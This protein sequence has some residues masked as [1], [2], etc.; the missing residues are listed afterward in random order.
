MLP[1]HLVAQDERAT[2]KLIGEARIV[3]LAAI[4]VI[5]LDGAATH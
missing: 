4:K 1:G 2:K 5:A 3:R